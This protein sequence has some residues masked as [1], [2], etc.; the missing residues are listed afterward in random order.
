M[1]FDSTDHHRALDVLADKIVS[2]YRLTDAEL[3]KKLGQRMAEIIQRDELPSNTDDLICE[4]LPTTD[5]KQ[6]F[7]KVKLDSSI[8]DSFSSAQV[9]AAID[10]IERL[11]GEI[12]SWGD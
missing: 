8:V 10:V 6:A 4:N 7:S 5:S 1:N 3:A 2:D 12:G 9:N 11:A